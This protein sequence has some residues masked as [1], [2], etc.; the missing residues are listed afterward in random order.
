MSV[1]T[2]YP[3]DV[4]GLSAEITRKVAQAYLTQ[5]KELLAWLKSNDLL[6]CPSK[7]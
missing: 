5:T 1:A 3:E 2:R 4:A 7:L 6:I